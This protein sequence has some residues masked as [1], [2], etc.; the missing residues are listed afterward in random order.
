MKSFLSVT[1]L[2]VGVCYKINWDLSGV[3]GVR[4]SGVIAM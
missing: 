1:Y 2:E 4:H 3:A